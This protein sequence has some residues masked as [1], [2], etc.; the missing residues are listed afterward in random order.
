MRM[1]LAF[2]LPLLCLGIL[3]SGCEM[4]TA[5]EPKTS[6]GTITETPVAVTPIT[7]T[8]ALPERMI[9]NGI[10]ERGSAT[11]PNTLLVFTEHHCAYCKEFE[12]Y[13][14]KK[15][16]PYIRSGEL[17]IQTAIVPLQKYPNSK[18]TMAA[19]F[20]AA[21]EGKGGAMLEKLLYE[22][23]AIE[24]H[25]TALG[26]SDAFTGCMASDSKADEILAAENF[27][28]SKEITLVPTLVLNGKQSTGLPYIEDLIAQIEAEIR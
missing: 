16:D 9:E 3:L 24:S 25:K 12:I 28:Q 4:P 15:L 21:D 11:A 26:L 19:L 10:L 13:H 14:M 6:T 20:C 5:N 8:G 2:L 1:R 17:K 23:A 22:P 18:V 7:G 27:A